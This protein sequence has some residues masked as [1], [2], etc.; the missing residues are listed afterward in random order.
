MLLVN[1]GAKYFQ[2]FKTEA[3]MTMNNALDNPERIP[4]YIL[5]VYATVGYAA[6]WLPILP[7][8]SCKYS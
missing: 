5:I 2:S 3:D 8:S 1:C 4:Y 7:R 6:L